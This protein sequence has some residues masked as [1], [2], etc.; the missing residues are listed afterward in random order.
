MISASAPRFRSLTWL[1]L[2][3]GLATVGDRTAELT[4][5]ELDGDKAVGA[6]LDR[7]LEL[8]RS[9]EV[10]LATKRPCTPSEGATMI[11]AGRDCLWRLT[12]GTPLDEEAVKARGLT[13]ID[14]GLNCLASTLSVA[15]AA[16]VASILKIYA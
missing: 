3:A 14:A 2:G 12:Q 10:V 9:L 15:D 11:A 4:A 16:W 5:A 6:E 8:A 13:P 7:L 1:G